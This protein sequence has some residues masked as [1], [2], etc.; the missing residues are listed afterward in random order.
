MANEIGT[1]LTEIP[2][3][4]ERILSDAERA[5][6]RKEERNNMLEEMLTDALKLGEKM[7]L[8]YTMGQVMR[9]GKMSWDDCK[10]L[11]LQIAEKA[12]LKV[13]DGLFDTQSSKMQR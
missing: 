9:L 11:L 7:P 12:N 6:E 8:K 1:T 10:K 2:T 3:F 4:G 5:E 13:P